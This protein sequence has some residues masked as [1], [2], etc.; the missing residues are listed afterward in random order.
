MVISI[1]AL[2]IAILLPS[3]A[4]ARDRARYIKWAGFSHNLRIDTRFYSYWNFE[5]QNDGDQ[6]LKNKAAGDPFKQAKEDIEPLMFD[7]YLGTSESVEANLDPDWITSTAQGA[8]WNG[9]GTLE[10]IAPTGTTADH[11][12]LKG[13]TNVGGGEFTVVGSIRYKQYNNWSR[14]IDWGNGDGIDNILT[15]NIGTTQDLRFEAHDTPGG[16]ATADSGGFWTPGDSQWATFV[17]TVVDEGGVAHYKAYINGQEKMDSNQA[18]RF[19]RKVTR[20]TNYLGRSN[21]G[22][23]WEFNGFM[24]ELGVMDGH[25]VDQD[26]IDMH[27][28]VSAVRKK[29]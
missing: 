8:R 26:W 24:D 28:S 13:D 14:Q 16:T 6:L 17:C 7:A 19:P 11:C 29:N 18:N 9:K 10:F 15:A 20:S 22:G 12:I 21:W 2:L 1:I 25:S 27:H 3:L 5:N 23:D 4:G